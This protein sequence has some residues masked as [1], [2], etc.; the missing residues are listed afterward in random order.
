MGLA[1]G[2]L[3]VMAGLLAASETAAQAVREGL[4]LCGGSVIPALFPF[5]VVSRLFVATGSAAALERLNSRSASRSPR[6][7]GAGRP[8]CCALGPV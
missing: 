1:L 5:L 8:R 2:L 3:A 6:P 7:S 4:A